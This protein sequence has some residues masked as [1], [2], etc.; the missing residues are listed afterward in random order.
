MKLGLTSALGIIVIAA[1][2]LGVAFRFTNLARQIYF[3]D[4]VWLSIRVAGHT[5][6]DWVR[7]FFDGG[8]HEVTTVRQY[9]QIASN[10]GIA[11]TVRA[12]ALDDAK[13]P[14]L[15]H[16]IAWAWERS[17][18]GSPAALRTLSALLGVLLLPAVY[19]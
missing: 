13:W 1:I 9:Q 19:W 14:P 4:E 10:T 15:Y 17:F 12:Q 2:V 6:D 16:V 18:G 5:Y 8:V 7:T 3:E 11:A